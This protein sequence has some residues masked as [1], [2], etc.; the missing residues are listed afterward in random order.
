MSLSQDPKRRQ[1]RC[2]SE[3]IQKC[4]CPKSK[5]YYEDD[6]IRKISDKLTP[7][8][9]HTSEYYTWYIVPTSE[10]YTWYMV[11]GLLKISEKRIPDTWYHTK[12][13]YHTD[14]Y[15]AVEARNLKKQEQI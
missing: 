7:G 11:P 3:D 5:K 4:L 10:Y 15:T 12:H 13:S 8:V 9:V 14:I 6:E 1:G 2:N